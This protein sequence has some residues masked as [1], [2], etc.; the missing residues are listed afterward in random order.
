MDRN[1][2]LCV[3]ECTIDPEDLVE[4]EPPIKKTRKT[5]SDDED[6]IDPDKAIEKTEKQRN[7]LERKLV[8][9]RNIKF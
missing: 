5:D 1:G 8:Q 7:N 2:Q 6:D 3:W 9:L 4:W